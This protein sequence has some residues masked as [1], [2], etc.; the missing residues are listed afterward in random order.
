MPRN[1]DQESQKRDWAS[2]NDIVIMNHLC[3]SGIMIG[4]AFLYFFIGSR[5]ASQAAPWASQKLL[6]YGVAGWFLH[7]MRIISNGDTHRSFIVFSTQCLPYRSRSS[8]NAHIATA[9]ILKNGTIVSN[10]RLYIRQ[11]LEN[12]TKRRENGMRCYETSVNDWGGVEATKPD[13][14][15]G[16]GCCDNIDPCHLR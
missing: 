9:T 11:L 1:E 10:I 15:V 6:W 8:S 12:H 16:L 14:C 3:P 4:V 5:N 13:I 7:T 2:T